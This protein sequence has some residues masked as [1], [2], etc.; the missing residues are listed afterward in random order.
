MG[1]SRSVCGGAH[2]TRSVR[3]RSPELQ[4]LLQT[5]MIFLQDTQKETKLLFL[6]P[7]EIRNVGGPSSISMPHLTSGQIHNQDILVV[8]PASN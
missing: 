2:E 8:H 4:V 7:G 6:F 5:L 1:V 3:T